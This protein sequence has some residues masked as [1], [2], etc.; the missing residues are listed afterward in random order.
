MQMS[1]AIVA[2]KPLCST[3]GRFEA[4]FG[5]LAVLANDNASRHF[6]CLMMDHGTAEVRCGR[7][8]RIS[9]AVLVLLPQSNDMPCKLQTCGIIKAVNKTLRTNGLRTFHEV[10]RHAGTSYLIAFAFSSKLHNLHVRGYC[11][12]VHTA[13]P[14]TS[15]VSRLGLIRR[16]QCIGSRG[17]QTERT[18]CTAASVAH[19]DC[20]GVVS[21]ARGFTDMHTA[22]I[23]A[24][25]R[26]TVGMEKSA[27]SNAKMQVEVVCCQVGQKRYTVWPAP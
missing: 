24:C 23:R 4:E 16:L 2:P 11:Q 13:G 14:A 8:V 12:D 15:C 22:S 27:D 19:T 21:D 1:A 5:K 10:L 20:E 3:C 7:V 25:C 18:I 9:H 26:A 6:A 17:G